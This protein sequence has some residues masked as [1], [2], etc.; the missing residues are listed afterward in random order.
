LT[1]ATGTLPGEQKASFALPGGEDKQRGFPANLASI[2]SLNSPDTATALFFQVLK[3]PFYPHVLVKGFLEIK[4]LVQLLL[5][6][7]IVQK[8][9]LSTLYSLNGNCISSLFS[10]FLETLILF[11]RALLGLSFLMSQS[12]T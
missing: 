8:G 9:G 11:E 3:G 12:Y 4:A 6:K 5:F 1:A 7:N 2:P 10:L